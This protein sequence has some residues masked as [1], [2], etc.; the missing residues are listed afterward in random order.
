VLRRV[1]DAVWND[2]DAY[3]LGA[4]VVVIVSLR[5]RPS[6]SLCVPPAEGFWYIDYVAL[7]GLVAAERKRD[8]NQMKS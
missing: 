4:E 8:D 1:V 6:S 3:N 7:A 5:L 2:G